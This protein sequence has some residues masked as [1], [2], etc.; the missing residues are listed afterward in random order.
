MPGAFLVGNRVQLRPLEESDADILTA[1]INDPEIRRCLLFRVPYS[2]RAEKEW[3]AS[4]SSGTAHPRQVAL[5]IELRH[6]PRL[7]GTVGLHGID[8]IHRRAMTGIFLSPPEL[9]GQ[10]Y[11]TEAKNLILDYAFGELGLHSLSTHVFAD[12]VASIRSVER[13]GYRRAGVLRQATYVKGRW[14]DNVVF[15]ILAE[16]WR[17]LRAGS[18]DADR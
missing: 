15:D 7:I 5:G 6:E 3:I 2:V 17:A 18:D 9:R 10:G 12:N 14:V 11:G 4:L 8:W 13:Q 1:W 16:E